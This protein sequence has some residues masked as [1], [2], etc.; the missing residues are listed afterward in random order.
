MGYGQLVTSEEKGA[1]HQNAY[2]C[3][4]VF[5]VKKKIKFWVISNMIASSVYHDG[6]KKRRKEKG[7]CRGRKKVKQEKEKRER[8]EKES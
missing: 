4:F 3:V 6:R 7:E 5:R 8:T 1:H 2:V